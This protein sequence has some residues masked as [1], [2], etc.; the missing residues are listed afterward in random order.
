M[1]PKRRQIC[2]HNCSTCIKKASS[3]NPA[4]T[5]YAAYTSKPQKASVVCVKKLFKKDSQLQKWGL[6]H[7][8]IGKDRRKE[9]VSNSGIHSNT[10][11]N[12]EK[13]STL[14][15]KLHVTVTKEET[16]RRNFRFCLTCTTKLLLFKILKSHSLSHDCYSSSVKTRVVEHREK[17]R[18]DFQKQF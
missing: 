6:S 5:K 16:E 7:L 11:S 17:W 10:F 12:S 14:S 2:P 18:Q 1:N 13:Y 3:E 15:S 4:G 8:R 9:L